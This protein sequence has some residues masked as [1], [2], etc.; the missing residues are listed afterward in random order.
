MPK[1]PSGSLRSP[2]PPMGEAS[3]AVHIRRRPCHP[4]RSEGSQAWKSV[5]CPAYEILRLRCAPLRM[6][7]GEMCVLF[8]K[9][10]ASRGRPRGSPLRARHPVPVVGE[11][12]APPVREKGTIIKKGNGEAVPMYGS[13]VCFPRRGKCP[14]GAKG[15]C[16]A[17]SPFRLTAL[18][19]FP[20]GGGFKGGAYTPP[21]L[22]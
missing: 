19:A 2:A 16:I 21:P 20:N 14:E 9:R 3:Q 22:S 11:G 13:P 12:L 1:A 7:C 4:E 18:A 17:E 6:T 15:V 8:N 5:P 10:C